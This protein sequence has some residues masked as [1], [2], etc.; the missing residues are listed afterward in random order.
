MLLA[1]KLTIIYTFNL[2]FDIITM[3]MQ[4]Q[5]VTIKKDINIK[6]DDTLHVFLNPKF[7]FFPIRE[8]FKLKVRDNEYVYKNDIVAMDTHGH[9]VYSSVSGRVLG[10]KEMPYVDGMLPSL[11]IENDFKENLKVRKSAKKYIGSYTRKEL[12]DVLSDTSVM[13]KGK[14]L[15]E[16]LDTTNIDIIINGVEN[17]PYFGNKQFILKDNV[18]ELLETIDLISVSLKAPRVVLA[19]K[20]NEEETINK[21]INVLGTYPNIELK[22]VSDAYPNGM[23][24][25]LKLKFKM[26]TALVLDITEIDLIYE[27]IKRERPVVEKYIT[28]TGNAVAPKQVIKVK[29][30]SLLSEIFVTQFNF[31]EEQ[32]DVYLNGMMTGNIINSLKLV[33]DS[34]IEGILVMKKTEEETEPCIKCGLCS[35]NCPMGLEPKYVYDHKGNVKKEY[36]ENCIG[37]GLCNYLCPSNIDLK[38]IMM[39]CDKK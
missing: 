19:V 21:L 3:V 11:V 31:T 35:K 14:Y 34:N 8:D 12:L 7:V 38:K 30:G 28:I 27:A 5:E 9:I 29:V 15:Y 36:Y 18:D 1:I 13:Y 10:V 39:G 22:L 24:E 37:C 2:K 20:N 4:M 16:K 26:P 33:V 17:E 6:L 25:I 23:G 32:V